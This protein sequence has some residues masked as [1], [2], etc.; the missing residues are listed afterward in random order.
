VFHEAEVRQLLDPDALLDG[1][2]IE[3]VAL[4]RGETAAPPGNEVNVPGAGFLLGMPAWRPGQPIG[5]KLVSVFH[6]NH[7]VGL[8]GTWR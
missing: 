6:G 3:L 5:V 4:S 7:R 1:L 2:A 8:P